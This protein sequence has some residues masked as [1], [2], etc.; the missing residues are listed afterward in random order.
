ML[1]LKDLSS[2]NPIEEVHPKHKL[3]SSK[4][5]GDENKSLRLEGCDGNGDGPFL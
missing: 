4:I 2:H 3:Q 5:L 1:L